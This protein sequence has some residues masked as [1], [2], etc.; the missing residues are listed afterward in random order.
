MSR[1]R[2]II[3]TGPTASGKTHLA[4]SLARHLDG[5]I[6]SADSRQVFRHLDI[7]T[8]KDLE[9]YGEIPYH[10]IDI[11]EPEE[12]F[13]LFEYLKLAQ[14]ALDDI[15]TRGKLPIICGGTP[16]YIKALLEGYSYSGGEPDEA[17]RQQL[18]SL[19]LE[20]LVDILKKEA[21]PEL[22]QR[23]DLT[24][25]RRVIRAIELARNAQMTQQE[26]F[27]SHPLILA[28]YFPREEIRARI[29]RRLTARL[30]H[31]LVEEVESLHQ[32][33]LS[34]ER[35]EWLGLEYR[36]LSRF[37]RGLL[38]RKEMEE[39]LF[40]HICQ[41]AKR[42]DGWFRSLE[43]SGHIIHWIPEGKE[44][45]ALSLARLWLEGKPLP[46]PALRLDDIRYGEKSQ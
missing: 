26:P 29:Q 39:Q 21:A 37:L 45:E 35:M 30:E 32:K 20:T 7:G 42:Q 40:Q 36:F 44:E 13:H 15:T 2:A 17:L 23:T 41:F 31:G 24:Q 27:L 4:V 28:P 46:P 12:P 9:E 6:I 10:L 8:G 34:W 22:F 43:R 14:T 38:S 11:L 5:E 3:L 25:A 1:P 16:L 19:P 33:G 18:A